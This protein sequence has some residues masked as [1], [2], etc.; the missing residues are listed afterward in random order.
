MWITDWSRDGR[1]IVYSKGGFVSQRSEIW[2]LPLVGNREPFPFLVTEFTDDVGCISPDGRWMAY[3]TQENL[4]NQ[5]YVAPFVPPVE[6]GGD[7][8]DKR[9]FSKWQ[10]SDEGDVGSLPLWNPKGGELFFIK[11]DGTI[12]SANV[13]TSG[14]TF[15]TGRVELVCKTDP[16]NFGRIG[17][18]VTPDGDH[19]IVNSFSSVSAPPITIVQ[20]WLLELEK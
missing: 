20:N 18:D 7:P 2:V 19:F 17:Y 6:A 13:D 3:A 15:R 8:N 4:G 10:V 14:D 11:A 16:W 1:Y 12:W 5:I 9:V